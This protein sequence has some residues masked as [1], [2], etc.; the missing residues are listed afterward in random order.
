MKLW[1]LT[2]LWTVSLLILSGCTTTPVP[3]KEDVVDSTLPIV[4]LTKSGVFPDINAI[5]FEW[6]SIKDSR[7]D[8]VY[9]YKYDPTNEEE[10]KGELTYFSTI[11]NR[12]A[13]HF[14]DRDIKADTKYMY[15][16]KT[17]SKDA[18][19][20]STRT[21]SVNSL[22]VLSSVSW[23]HSIAGMPRATKLIWRPHTNQKVKSYIIERRTIKEKKFE[24]IARVE[25]RL[26]VEYIDSD[27]KDN[28]KYSYRIRVL[29]F[30]DI[31]STPSVI[32]NVITKP[33][34]K[35]VKGLR[36]TLDLPKK[37]KIMW[38]KS[39]D[40]D[41]SV[42][43]VYR[44]EV[45]DDSYELIAKLH[46]NYHIDKLDETGVEYY[47]RVSVVDKD[48]L[49]SIHDNRSVTG[50]TLG[51]PKTPILVE[52]N[53]MGD[54]IEISWSNS[55]ER[56]KE[57]LIRKTEKKGWFNTVTTDIKGI[58]SPIYID[59]KIQADATYTYSVYAIDADSI[60]S[61]ASPAVSVKT[62][63]SKTIIKASQKSVQDEVRV[64]KQ[65]TIN[66][67]DQKI[68]PVQDL[69]LNEN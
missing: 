40:K 25:G 41:F 51:K 11:D 52:A 55:D 1:T 56:T 20:K 12:F 4:E 18:K 49:E 50:A 35:E 29:T 63:E 2:T 19:S 60:L 61:E 69:K 68:I 27:L 30:D 57:Y 10:K 23:V 66:V 44:S 22:P 39:L 32:V 7:V 48:G 15:M 64:L 34:P 58:R 13:T 21:I 36:A 33:L 31:L 26:N 42:Y 5:A 43:H 3:K 47:Y 8:G 16:F 59:K 17:F 14:V 6:K 28:Y 62:P 54:K 9:V 24:E 53:L 45:K 65:E 46:N 38:S 37:I 67:Q